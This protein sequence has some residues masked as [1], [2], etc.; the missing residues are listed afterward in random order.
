MAGV[1]VLL[2]SVSVNVNSFELSHVETIHCLPAAED[3]PEV[4]ATHRHASRKH[5]M[6]TWKRTECDS[7]NRARPTATSARTRGDAS[8][9]ACSTMNSHQVPRPDTANGTGPYK[10]SN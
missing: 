2:C 3:A 6:R 9:T 8:Y 10:P 4:H 7:A 5:Q 1:G